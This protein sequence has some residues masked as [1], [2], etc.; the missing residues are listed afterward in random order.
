MVDADHWRG[1]WLRTLALFDGYAVVI[2][3]HDDPATF[4]GV[5]SVDGDG[6]PRL[7]GRRLREPGRIRL[8]VEAPP[9]REQPMLPLVPAGA[10]WLVETRWL[11][12]PGEPVTT[13]RL[14]TEIGANGYADFRRQ[15]QGGAVRVSV[16][17][18]DPE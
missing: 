1:Y 9:V 17:P 14:E 7:D 15:A 5:V 2:R 10:G 8:I 4:R 3:L 11:R 12:C 18:G 6:A 16:R 13:A